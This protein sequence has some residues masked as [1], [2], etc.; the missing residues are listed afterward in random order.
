[1]KLYNDWKPVDDPLFGWD[2]RTADLVCRQLDC[3]SAVSA[4]IKDNRSVRHVWKINASSVLSASALRDYKSVTPQNSSTSLEITC[5]DLLFQP[6][7]SVSP[8][9]DGIYE[10]SNFTISCSIKPQYP[11]GSFQLTFNTSNTA[12]VYT[13]KAVNHTAHFLFPAANHGHQGNYSCSVFSHKFSSVSQPLY[14]SISASPT[15][16]IVRLVG[17]LLTLALLLSAI[18]LHKMTTRGQESG[19][20]ENIELDYCNLHPELK[21]GQMKRM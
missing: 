10:S 1:M 4:K 16:F 13:Q 17:L 8:S 15:V 18:G 21:V 6:M 11:G 20:Q 3:G 12:N 2:L 5:S 9:I 14:L 19:R 7:I